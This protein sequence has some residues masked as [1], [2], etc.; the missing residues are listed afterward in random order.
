VTH[1]GIASQ[2][3]TAAV[4]AAAAAAAAAAGSPPKRLTHADGE[5][6]INDLLA[7]NPAGKC[8]DV[9]GVAKVQACG[10][11]QV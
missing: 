2:L 5:Q 4:V 9:G 1:P 6:T 3:L 11:D 8:A 10:R 7:A